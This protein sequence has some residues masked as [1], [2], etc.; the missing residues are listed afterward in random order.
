MSGYGNVDYRFEGGDSERASAS[1]M[2]IGEANASGGNVVSPYEIKTLV[3][4]A[5]RRVLIMA[6]TTGVKTF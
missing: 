6:G 1:Y 5:G 2:R 4:I 3:P